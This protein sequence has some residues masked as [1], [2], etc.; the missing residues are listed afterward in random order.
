MPALR[1]ILTAVAGIAAVASALPALPK[2]NSRA[3]ELYE[4]RERQVTASGLP[5][6]ITDVDI[7]QL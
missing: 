2:L 7:L 3:L 4:L 5:A 6:N 1:Q